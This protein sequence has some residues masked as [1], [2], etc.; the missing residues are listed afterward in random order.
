MKIILDIAE[1]KCNELNMFQ[2]K[3]NLINCGWL[4]IGV[5][6]RVKQSGL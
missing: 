2:I 3:L 5:K 6:C 4:I 1:R